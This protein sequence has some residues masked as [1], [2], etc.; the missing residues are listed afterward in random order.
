MAKSKTSRKLFATTATAAMV[1]SAV[2][3]TASFA[4]EQEQTFPDVPTDHGY[5]NVI[6]DLAEAEVVTGYTDGEFKM[7]NLVTRAEASV[8]VSKILELDTNAP[9]TDF[10][11]VKEDVWYTNSINA[12][13]EA[14]HIVGLND[15]TFGVNNQMTRAQFAQLVV[16]AYN[17]PGEEADLPFTDL[18]DG[19]WYQPAIQTLYANG[20]ISGQDA[21]T[22]GPNDPIKRGDFAWL[23]ANTDYKFGNMLPKP[24]EGIPGFAIDSVNAVANADYTIDVTGE[25]SGADR[26]TV[27]IDGEEKAADLNEDGSFSFSS[28]VLEVGTYEVTVKAYLGDESIS[29]TTKVAVVDE[30]TSIAGFVLEK[31]DEGEDVG[32]AGATVTVD[33]KEYTTNAQGFYQVKNLD[34]DKFYEINIT[35]PS[36]ESQT[37]KVRVTNDKVSSVITENFT[38]ISQEDIAISG[39]IVNKVTG[40]DVSGSTV[41]FQAYSEDLGEWVTIHSENVEADGSYSIDQSDKG[42]TPGNFIE[43]GGKYRLSIDK[44]GYHSESVEFT[45]NDNRQITELGAT[46]LTEIKKIDISGKI[47]RDGDPVE[48]AIVELAGQT[49]KTE[50][51]GNY[52]FEDLKLTSDDYNLSA[53]Y[54]GGAGLDTVT[55]KSL[56]VEE[57]KNLTGQNIELAL[58]AD[59]DFYLGAPVSKTINKT[60][61]FATVHNSDGAVVAGSSDLTSVNG[62]VKFNF[63]KNLTAGDYTVVV[64]GDYVVAKEYSFTVTDADVSKYVDTEGEDKPVKLVKGEQYEAVLGG[65]ITGIAEAVNITNPGEASDETVDKTVV[66]LKDSNGK[67]VAREVVNVDEI[68]KDATTETATAGEFGGLVPGKY[69]V[70]IYKPGY[71]SGE[72]TVSVSEGK[73]AVVKS[74]SLDLVIPTK[75]ASVQ[76][77]VRNNDSLSAVSD[78]TVS[79]YQNG[80]LVDT[81]TAAEYEAGVDL[82]PGIFTVVVRDN[83]VDSDSNGGTAEYKTY[84]EQL[85]LN[86][87][88][89]V[90]NHH[91]G[92]EEAAAQI[93]VSVVDG[94]NKDLNANTITIY[95]AWADRSEDVNIEAGAY[96][97]STDSQHLFDNLSVGEYSI[98]VEE[99]GYNTQTLGV[100]LEDNEDFK[101]KIVMSETEATY[102]VTVNTVLEGSS[103]DQKSKVVVFDEAGNIVHTDENGNEFELANGS[104]KV[105]AYIDGYYVSSQ[106]LTIDRDGKTVLL[107]VKEGNWDTSK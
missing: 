94:A 97:V 105:A 54:T 45:V 88:D 4:A 26:V 106:E 89:K 53:T 49:V 67:E 57:G 63:N 72:S 56:S 95:D 40:E 79:F 93:D 47:T 5:F 33:G 7:G 77:L 80:N 107:E 74:N 10:P 101:T 12:L 73:E 21:N 96:Q 44:T 68:T 19:A 100:S 71:K 6:N 13:Y 1:A 65:S 8:M 39:E 81:A 37:E 31:N 61:L 25:V 16:E 28:D 35:K 78:A 52:T 76:G 23:L 70:E 2:A 66:V 102:P 46:E 98:V 104:Y 15:G 17:I 99:E 38:E 36:Y 3:P 11:D 69:T 29:K 103:N 22:F 92:L 62:D 32:V 58:G 84:V 85:T 82:W 64:A 50:S 20:L 27:T 75:Y 90:E 18:K 86:N 24:D 14:G 83:A 91:L 60:N 34:T 59:V 9:S 51:N 43:F 30:E 41:S 42:I 87:K 55:T 48:N